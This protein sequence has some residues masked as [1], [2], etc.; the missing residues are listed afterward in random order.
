MSSHWLKP[1][2]RRLPRLIRRPV[3][4]LLLLAAAACT[5]DATTTPVPTPSP[6][7]LPTVAAEPTD[8]LPPETPVPTVEGP[9][10]PTAT[11]LAIKAATPTP[12]HWLNPVPAPPYSPP[13]WWEY[14]NP[15][16]DFYGEPV[17]GGTLRINF[18]EPLEH[19]NV[20]GAYSGAAARFRIPTGATLVMEDPYDAGTPLIPDLAERWELHEGQAGVTFSFWLDTLWHNG[21]PFSCEDARFSLETMATG[22]GLTASYM[23]SRLSHVLLAETNCLDVITLEV[24]FDRPTAIPFHAFSNPR[25]LVFNKAWFEQGGEE[26]MFKDVSVGMG[27]FMWEEGQQVG[28]DEQRF[29]RNPNYFINIKELP[30]VDE[31]VIYGILDEAAQQA[32]MLAHQTDWHWVRNWEQYDAYVDHDQISTVIGPNRSNFRLEFNSRNAPFDNMRVR[33]AIVMAIDRKEAVNRLF[34]GYGVLGGFGYS[35]G[36]PWELSQERLCSVPGWCVSDNMA[37]IRA[38][39]RNILMQEGFDFGVS[40]ALVVADR[41]EPFS[42]VFIKEQLG[43]LGIKTRDPEP[44]WVPCPPCGEPDKDIIITDGGLRADDPNAGVARYLACDS[45]GKEQN[46]ELCTPDMIALLDQAQVELDPDKRL[47]L[48]HEIELA[49]MKQYSSFPI[50]WEQEAVAFWPEVRGYV[51]HPSPTGSFLKFMH[52]WIDPAHRDDTGYS[53]QTSGIPGGM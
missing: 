15:P 36:S 6:T 23:K 1:C 29:E 33:Q 16:S 31:L 14:W 45:Y 51:H 27:P 10:F 3:L 22:E 9:A 53:G 46:P 20:W 37:A 2:F 13:E 5:A 35:P 43:Q 30:Y 19:A 39:A 50:Y 38:E 7:A 49:A 52:M 40:Y 28:V 47:A 32:A 8:A 44:P 12:G 26:A 11:P 18:Q 4:A 25:A 42:S 17:Y 48:A 21:E 41:N 34:N 24:R